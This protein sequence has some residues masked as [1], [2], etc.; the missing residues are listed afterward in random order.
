MAPPKR[1]KSSTPSAPSSTTNSTNIRK[2]NDVSQ[3]VQHLYNNYVEQ[4]PQRVKLIDTFMVF[5][6]VVGAL[7]F[8]YCLIGGNFPFNAFLSGFSATVGQFVLT[9]SLRMQTNPENASEFKSVSTERAFADYIFGSL[10]LHF[11]CVNFIN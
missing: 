2:T 8:L 3:I 11:F 1:A 4:T 9:A 10:I 6:V 7:Q 5:L